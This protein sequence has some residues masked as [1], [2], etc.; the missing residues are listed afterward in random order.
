MTDNPEQLRQELERQ[1]ETIRVLQNE[2]SETNQGL[3]ALSMEL[4]KRVDEHT[5]E[6]QAAQSELKRTLTTL[7]ET[8]DRTDFALSATH[9]GTWDLNLE[10]GSVQRSDVFDQIFGY[11]K[12]LEQWTYPLFLA[13]SARGPGKGRWQLS[14]HA[15]DRQRLGLRMP[16]P[17]PKWSDSLD[18]RSWSLAR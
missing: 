2:L 18:L 16:D 10:D 15:R 6:L 5:T 3:V 7:R 8:E 17:M 12:P 9:I 4:E 13:C 11:E 1:A 14:G